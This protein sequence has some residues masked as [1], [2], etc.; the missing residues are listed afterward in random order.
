MTAFLDITRHIEA[1]CKQEPA[2]AGGDVVRSRL[3]KLAE[4]SPA[5]IRIFPQGADGKAAAVRGGHHSWQYEIAV[6]CYARAPASGANAGDAEAE[7]D[8]L[9][10]QVWARLAQAAPPAGV[11]SL[12]NEPRLAFSVIESETPMCLV[13]LTF[14]VALSTV[15]AT[16][17]PWS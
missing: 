8:A 7:A 11:Q 6:E 17:T 14:G 1:V 12:L 15:N 4:D 5:G 3:L 16:L 9:V 13:T 2:L 10:A